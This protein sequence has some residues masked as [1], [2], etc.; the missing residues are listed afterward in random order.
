MKKVHTFKNSPAS[1]FKNKPLSKKQ[2]LPIKRPRSRSTT[3]LSR[4]STKTQLEK[5]KVSLDIDNRNKKIEE[6]KKKYAEK[7]IILT[8]DA[9]DKKSKNEKQKIEEKIVDNINELKAFEFYK[10][11]VQNDVKNSRSFKN[12][13]STKNYRGTPEFKKNFEGKKS[14]CEQQRCIR[15]KFPNQLL[16][17]YK[18]FSS[19]ER[20]SK[21]MFVSKLLDSRCSKSEIKVALKNIIFKK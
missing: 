19:P 13:E 15:S 4:T 12:N 10:N 9:F 14:N 8:D 21:S 6:V 1:N 17:E 2:E 18:F 16:R 20:N 3:P 11:T 5:L 7:K